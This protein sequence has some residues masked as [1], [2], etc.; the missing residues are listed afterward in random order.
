MSKNKKILM[1]L[2]KGGASQSDIAAALHVSKRDVSTAAKAMREHDLTFDAVSSMDAGAVDDLLFPKEKRKLNNAYLQPDMEALVERK[3]KSRKL[4]VKLF[5]IEYCE[6]AAAEGRLA[7]AY[8]TFCEMFAEKAEKM[9]ATRHFVHEAG[10]KCYIDWAGDTAS[11]TDKLTGAKTKAYVLVVTLPFSGKFWAEGF[12]SMGQK[13]WQEGHMHAFEEF[14]GVPRMWVPDNAATA[15][16]RTNIPRV[17]LVNREYERFAEHYGAAI[18]PARVRKP[19]DK[20]VAES[21]VDLVEQWIIGPASETAFYTLEEFNEFCAERTAWLNSRPFSA[22]DGSRESVFKEEECMHLEPL[23]AER[24]EMCE[25]R[26]AKV[27]P[28]YHVTVDY[29]HYSV[30]HSLIGE[31]VDVKLTPGEVSILH[32]GRTV[33]AHPRLRGRK[34]QYSTN[35]DHMPENHAALDDPWSPDRFRS[36]A[37]RVGPETEAAVGRVLASR[38]VVE[39]SFV[40]C[41]NILGLSKTYAPELLERA[42][43]KANAASALPS[44]TSLKKAILAMRA[45]DAQ[46]RANNRPLAQTAPGDLVDRAKS[47]GRLRGAEAYRR[48]GE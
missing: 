17:T 36:W 45:A 16:D 39:Q 23:P 28:D 38:A 19:R 21:C 41:R 20:S 9:D 3:K 30:D 6:R 24:Y 12:C 42:C 27:A 33:A 47:A 22:K 8:Q 18:V 11:L 5:W 4:P 46:V 48:G 34:G 7:Y 15:T 31:Q 25:W 10:A 13:P 29:M 32:G 43:A 2:T 26:S 14:C 1:M 37:R 44:Y 40:S 35:A